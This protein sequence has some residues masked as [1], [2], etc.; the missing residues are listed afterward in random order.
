MG[1]VA[2][3]LFPRVCLM[4]QRLWLTV[5]VGV[6][7]GVGPKLL[8]QST[9]PLG[10][11]PDVLP[12][13]R[14]QTVYVPWEELDRLLT[15]DEPGVLVSREEFDR[16]LARSRVEGGMEVGEPE[17]I[18]A[19]YQGRVEN[20]SLFLEA[21]L[22]GRSAGQ[23]P[24]VWRLPLRGLAIEAAAL[25]EQSVRMAR[26]SCGDLLVQI[27]GPGPHRLRLKLS[28]PLLSRGGELS[29]LLGL[30]RIP[31]AQLKLMIPPGKH[32]S[33]G[34]LALTGLRI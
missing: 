10:S 2:L 3:G 13:N 23:E 32:L 18:S 30:P 24:G 22:T 27:P 14:P 34:D 16:L 17:G 20:D 1:F 33:W 11:R 8:A 31:V 15:D 28:A 12:S 7:L 19:E 4:S 6:L 5:L 25:D 21:V 29:A 9:Q 26:E